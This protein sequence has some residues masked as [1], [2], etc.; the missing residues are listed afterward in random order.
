MG[1]P[2]RANIFQT[3]SEAQLHFARFPIQVTILFSPSDLD[4]QDHLRTLFVGRELSLTC[5]P[6]LIHMLS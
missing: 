3:G 5:P 4:F 2:L 1:F 6:K